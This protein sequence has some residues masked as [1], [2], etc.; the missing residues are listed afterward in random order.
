MSDR[1]VLV[2][3]TDPKADSIAVEE[4]ET[5][6]NG[7]GR[8]LYPV[9]LSRRAIPV[10]EDDQH[11]KDIEYAVDALEV[12]AKQH[13]ERAHDMEE[14]SPADAMFRG[15][16]RERRDAA[17]RLRAAFNVDTEDDNE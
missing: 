17:M 9:R 2:R 15:L 12:L 13:M 5:V 16:A 14:G 11:G 10:P 7:D 1:L 8:Y 3:V 4:L 6:T